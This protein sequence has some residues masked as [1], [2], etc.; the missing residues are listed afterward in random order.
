MSKEI[1]NQFTEACSNGDLDTVK[2][3]LVTGQYKFDEYE[4]FYIA[5]R[6]E[7]I[8]IVDYLLEYLHT[9]QDLKVIFN[10]A[11]CFVFSLCLQRQISY[12][13]THPKFKEFIDIH[14]GNDLGLDSAVAQGNLALV[15]YLLTAPELDEHAD[16]H[17]NN[18]SA[19]VKACI[20]SHFHIVEYF[21]T[22]TDLTEE[23]RHFRCIDLAFQKIIRMLN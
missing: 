13:L 6:N 5:C 23:Q 19:L 7:N 16:I 17:A 15:K 12:F 2:N 8:K 22:S 11:L 21:L 20:F 9:N 14:I 10:D 4:P 18:D 3:L 1:K